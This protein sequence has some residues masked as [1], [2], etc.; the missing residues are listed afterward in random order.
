MQ[1]IL[2]LLMCEKK[3]ES[4]CKSQMRAHRTLKITWKIFVP[5]QGAWSLSQQTK[6]NQEDGWAGVRNIYKIKMWAHDAK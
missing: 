1:E 6:E 5:Q 3:K 2:I 4:G